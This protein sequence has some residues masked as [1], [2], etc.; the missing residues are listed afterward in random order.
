MEL[1]QHMSF[2][3]VA[4]VDCTKF[5]APLLVPRKSPLL[6]LLLLVGY[7]RFVEQL[8]GPHNYLVELTVADCKMSVELLLVLHTNQVELR[9][10]KLV[11]S[12]TM[13]VE[14]HLALQRR[15]IV[16]Q[17]GGQLLEEHHNQI[18]ALLLA[19]A[20]PRKLVLAVVSI[21][22]WMVSSDAPLH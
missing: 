21:L 10:Q 9:K 5:A 12:Y 13:F 6:L 18:V 19:S 7:M 20:V 3:E 15:S 17:G 16:E 1:D 2:V 22:D 4:V 8:L 14:M 11:V